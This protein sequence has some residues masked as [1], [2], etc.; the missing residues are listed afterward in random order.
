M[1]RTRESND[2]MAVLGRPRAQS[3]ID[4][5]TSY[6]IVILV[7]SV[8][9]Y[10]ILQLG[11]FNSQIAPNYCNAAPSFS[12]SAYIIYPNGTLTFLLGQTLGGSISITGI[13]CSSVIN[14]TGNGPAFGNVQLTGSNTFYPTNGFAK[15]TILRSNSPQ[16]FSIYCYNSGSGIP[17][18]AP[19]GSGFI[20][21]LWLNYT[22]SGLPSNYITKQQVLSFSTS[23]T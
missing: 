12:C 22:Y 11:V 8:T 2:P 21:Y 20:G 14:G 19:L 18:K 4:F 23:Y 7:L 16:E 13:G 6:G 3:A 10:V 17:A 9:I 5:I 1:E 15:G